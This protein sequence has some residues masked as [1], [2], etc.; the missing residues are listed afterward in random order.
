MRRE[1]VHE[2][3]GGGVVR[4]PQIADGGRQRRE[5]HEEI[6]IDVTGRQ[7]QVVGAEGLRRE[8]AAE[9]VGRLL[10]DEA[11]RRHAGAVDDAVQLLVLLAHRRD[12]LFDLVRILEIDLPVFDLRC[13]G[14]HRF[15][16]RLP[17][18]GIADVGR[19]GPARQDDGRVHGAGE[20]LVREQHAQSA[21]AAGDQVDPLVLEGAVRR[22]E[23]SRRPPAGSA[24]SRRAWCPGRTGPACRACGRVRH[25][26]APPAPLSRSPR[27]RTRPVPRA[28]GSRVSPS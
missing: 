4:L 10:Q 12:Q 2:P 27:R 18:G 14:L 7:V 28:A 23:R 9:F 1:R 6:E 13:A 15:Q 20:D 16:H 11:V 19:R 5:Q 22:R 26:A 25:A 17:G 24:R 8:H 3:V 21:E